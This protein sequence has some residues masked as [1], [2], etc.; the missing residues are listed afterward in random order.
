MMLMRIAPIEAAIAALGRWANDGYEIAIVTGRP[1]DSYE[2]VVGVA[3]ALS[4]AAPIF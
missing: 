1:P 3:G 2:P 4:R